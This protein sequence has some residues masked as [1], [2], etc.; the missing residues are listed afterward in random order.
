MFEYDLLIILLV[1]AFYGPPFV[2]VLIC[3]TV[4]YVRPVR[5]ICRV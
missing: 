5:N 3:T 4:E 2:C 1:V